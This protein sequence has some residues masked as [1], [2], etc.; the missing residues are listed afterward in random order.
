MGVPPAIALSLVDAMVAF[1]DTP[2]LLLDGDLTVVA[3]SASLCHAFGLAPAVVAGHSI[4][5]MGSGEWDV[6]RLR[7]LLDAV[8]GGG[9]EIAAYE[10]ELAAPNGRRTL[11]F[12]AHKLAYDDLGNTRVLLSIADITDRRAAKRLNEQLLA[13][14]LLLNRELQ[15]RVANSLQII[16]SVLMQSAKRVGSDESRAHLQQAHNRVLSIAEVQRQL[17]TTGADAVAL[18][19][20]LTQLCAS[21]AASMIPDPDRIALKVEVD[22]SAVGSD[23]SVSLGLMVTE[24][25]INALKHAFPDDRLSNGRHGTIRVTYRGDDLATDHAATGAHSPA[26]NART[27]AAWTLTVTDDGVGMAANGTAA[28]GL[29]T[30]IVEALVGQRQARLTIASAHPG[31]TITIRHEPAGGKGADVLPLIRAV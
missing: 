30:S 6:P 17:A 29:G 8:V 2:L 27:A 21:I 20:Y 15:H 4:F 19:P 13:D 12:N 25:V 11:I 16:A 18:R 3:V 1:S 24:R 5:A 28:A 10:M 7:S 26:G 22:D 14:K 23:A 9:S 31:T